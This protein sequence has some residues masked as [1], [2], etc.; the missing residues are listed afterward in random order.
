MLSQIRA[1]AGLTVLGLG[2]LAQASAQEVLASPDDWKARSLS[3]LRQGLA[4]TTSEEQRQALLDCYLTFCPELA[5][6]LGVDLPDAAGATGLG[7]GTAVAGH[8]LQA[9]QTM[10][11]D[12][13]GPALDGLWARAKA[14]AVNVHR[15]KY[16][17]IHYA[18][19][20]VGSPAP[21]QLPTLGTGFETA[22]AALVDGWKY[23]A[24]KTVHSL[25][26]RYHV[27]ICDLSALEF[28]ADVAGMCL[29][30]PL[31]G[32]IILL[33]R[34]ALSRASPSG[35]LELAAHELYHACQAEY[36]GTWLYLVSGW[37]LEGSATWAAYE[38]ER[39][40]GTKGTARDGATAMWRVQSRTYLKAPER[41][42][43]SYKYEGAL[44]WSFLADNHKLDLAGPD[45]PWMV[46]RRFWEALSRTPLPSLGV[47]A[48]MDEALANAPDDC[49]AFA[50]AFGAF[51][52]EN[53]LLR[54]ADPALS[55]YAEH[56]GLLESPRNHLLSLDFRDFPVS[57]KSSANG[58]VRHLDGWANGYI[59]MRVAAGPP[60]R[61]RVEFAGETGRSWTLDACAV[62]NRHIAHH[63][64]SALNG[65][66]Q[67]AFDVS[68]YPGGFSATVLTIGKTDEGV[69]EYALTFEDYPLIT[70][71]R[72][73]PAQPKADDNVTVTAQVADGTGINRA[74]CQ[75]RAPGS[76][77]E[78][79]AMGRRAQDRYATTESIPAAALTADVEY[80][81]V[82]T[83]TGGL[84]ETSES[85]WIRVPEEG[86]LETVDAFMKAL[87]ARDWS[88][89]F[90]H[91]ARD[92]GQD[93][94]ALRDKWTRVLRAAFERADITDWQAS[95]ADET[96]DTFAAL[97]A[98]SVRDTRTRAASDN[99]IV[100]SLVRQGTWRIRS[101][102]TP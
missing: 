62:Y 15:T 64:P 47:V 88:R 1:T 101:I 45:E 41:A 4:A 9:A 7:C 98:F 51:G 97:V 42:L 16:F 100:V 94:A 11:R 2:A 65:H 3:C 58:E 67:A 79:L 61:M 55:C 91:I 66:D 46:A 14:T 5:E 77:W 60:R 74:A 18:T 68:V 99:R 86:P 57:S 49:D 71:V 52:A 31:G 40:H 75:W 93:E 29:A 36:V 95:K 50:E 63:D 33:D 38:V 44:L 81:I 80:R 76:P 70:N 32:S 73:Y 54:H 78:E 59:A 12:A 90:T 83:D 22:R 34:E 69:G 30:S 28:I 53:G 102:K 82:A 96:P 13:I 39:D 85:Y 92:P 84:V 43:S 17:A 10:S 26:G 6:D 23:R 8:I 20:P 25:D 87:Q 72:H 37:A 27:Y 24:P 19:P 21:T 56:W 48:S 35:L 89:A